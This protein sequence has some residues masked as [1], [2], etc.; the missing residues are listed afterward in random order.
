MCFCALL[1]LKLLDCNTPQYLQSP[2][3]ILPNSLDMNRNQTINTF[4]VRRASTID[5]ALAHLPL[6][7]FHQAWVFFFAVCKAKHDKPQTLNYFSFLLSLYLLIT[8][9]FSIFSSVNDARFFQNLIN[10][11]PVPS[12]AVILTKADPYRSA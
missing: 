2:P 5:A 11:I 1:F 12:E 6:R 7:T 10:I 8:V 3:S 4:Y 9:K